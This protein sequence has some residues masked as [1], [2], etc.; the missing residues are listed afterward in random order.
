MGADFNKPIIMDQPFSGNNPQ[1]CFKYFDKYVE[2]LKFYNISTGI[3][4][5]VDGNEDKVNK[6]MEFRKIVDNGEWYGFSVKEILSLDI[7]YLKKLNEIFR[8]NGSYKSILSY[9]NLIYVK[10]ENK[11]KVINL[12]ANNFSKYQVLLEEIDDST[13]DYFINDTKYVDGII[14]YINSDW[15]QSIFIKSKYSDIGYEY[16]YNLIN[17]DESLFAKAIRI[18]SNGKLFKFID[19]SISKICNDLISYDGNSFRLNNETSNIILD[20]NIK[21]T[22]YL[23]TNGLGIV[24]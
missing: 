9:R 18:I 16:V 8:N 1:A 19:P 12:L 14:D 6:L 17:V 10:D 20:R 4:T 3:Y 23:K 13:I 22:N 11:E 21:L 7:E 2:M 15:N 5:F 24:S